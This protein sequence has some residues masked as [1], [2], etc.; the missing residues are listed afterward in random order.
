MINFIN[1]D[2]RNSPY[3]FNCPFVS[4]GLIF[5]AVQLKS[6]GSKK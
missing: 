2:G 6:V 3:S 4:V 5:S 1:S